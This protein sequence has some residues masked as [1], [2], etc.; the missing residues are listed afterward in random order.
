MA[1]HMRNNCYFIS[2]AETSSTAEGI[3][4]EGGGGLR[5]QP[6]SFLF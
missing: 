3:G 4:E 6:I 5:E 1:E 2:W